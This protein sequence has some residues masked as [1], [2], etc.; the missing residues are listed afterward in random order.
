MFVLAKN[1][2]QT[3]FHSGALFPLIGERVGGAVGLRGTVK[4]LQAILIAKDSI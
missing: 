1:A 3:L 2:T 4:L